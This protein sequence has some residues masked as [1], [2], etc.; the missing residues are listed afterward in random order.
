MEQALPKQADITFGFARRVISFAVKHGQLEHNQL[1]G[2][3]AAYEADRSERIW[4]HEQVDALRLA[5]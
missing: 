4:T 3:D 1:K 2:I 5:G